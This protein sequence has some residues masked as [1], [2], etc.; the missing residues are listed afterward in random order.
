MKKLFTKAVSVIL[1]LAIS[2][3]ALTAVTS[4]TVDYY[5]V[6]ATIFN[7]TL[8]F[9]TASGQFFRLNEYGQAVISDGNNTGRWYWNYVSRILVL[10]NFQFTTVAP[11][12][13]YILSDGST[14][15]TTAGEVQVALM[16]NNLI[17]C[18]QSYMD[19]QSYGIL[20][21]SSLKFVGDGT[22]TVNGGNSADVSSGI[23]VSGNITFDQYATVYAQGGESTNQSSGIVT[24]NYG[25]ITINTGANVTAKGG[26][27]WIAGYGIIPQGVLQIIDGTLIASTYSYNTCAVYYGSMIMLP[28]KYVWRVGNNTLEDPGIAYNQDQTIPFVNNSNYKFVKITTDA[29]ESAATNP[30][31]GGALSDDDV[32]EDGLLDTEPAGSYFNEESVI[33]IEINGEETL[34][35]SIAHYIT[36]ETVSLGAII[37]LAF[38]YFLV[39]RYKFK[40]RQ[41]ND[42]W[43]LD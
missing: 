1:T 21:L 42:D 28:A 40:K 20:S 34:M 17:S 4:A 29:S 5:A 31:D 39:Y 8:Y 11:I 13:I 22:L 41:R 43:Q 35:N 9:D 30:S 33:N 24:N 2:L 14:A 7:Y 38:I 18:S 12:A 19:S 37:S 3:S 26:K 15:G 25:N 27:A 6:P 36:P 32:D 23:F 10:T 16:G